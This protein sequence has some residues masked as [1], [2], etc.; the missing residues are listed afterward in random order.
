[1]LEFRNAGPETPLRRTRAHRGAPSSGCGAARRQGDAHRRALRR[2]RRARGARAHFLQ[3]I[4]RGPGGDRDHRQPAGRR[5]RDRHGGRREGRARRPDAHLRG[6]EPQ[7]D[8]ASGRESGLRPDQGLRRRRQHRHAELR[9]DGERL[10]PGEDGGRIRHV[11]KSESRQAQLLL[12]GPRQLEPPGDGVLR[13]PRGPGHGAHPVQVHGGREQRRAR[14]ALARGDRAQRRGHSFR[15]GRAHPAPGRD[16]AEALGLPPRGAARR[17][18]RSRIRVRFVVRPA[19]AG[20]DTRGG[21]RSNQRGGG[22]AAARAGDTRAARRPGRRA[23]PLEPRGVRAADPRGLRGH[24]QGGEGRRPHRMSAVIDLHAHVI[25]ADAQRYP[26]AP[27]SGRQSDWS[28]ERP[29]SFQRMIAA[30][31]EAG[32]AKAALVQASTCY[33]HDNSYVADAVAAHPERFT[34]VF[35]VD[36]LQRDARERIDYWVS[37]DLAGLRVFIAGHTAAVKDTRL[38]DSR[39]FPAW[40]HAGKAG[41]PVCVQ[42]RAAGLPQLAAVLERFPR[43]RVILDHM[44]RPAIEDGPPY[45]AA[46]SLFSLARYGNLY[47]KLTTHNVRE[48]RAGKSL[49]ASFFARVVEKFGASRIAWGSN[50]PA[51]EGSLP[52]LLAEAR[53]ALAALPSRDHDWIF[54]RTAQSLYPALA[55]P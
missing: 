25:S 47:L 48:S 21:D 51:S 7:R 2:G 6:F 9:A 37:K 38:D 33:G 40:E 31:D 26:L 1:M 12:R 52:G 3:R 45:A 49:P 20:E 22:E 44:A 35:S 42:L 14:L 36:V 32:I 41:I 16:F 4:G 55:G 39:S 30:M 27:L 18:E 15:Q 8:R 34:G 24:G 29:V 13:E 43:V 54:F 5:R 19:R 53:A 23:A 11:R 46:A 50:Y 10:G 17:R 28:R